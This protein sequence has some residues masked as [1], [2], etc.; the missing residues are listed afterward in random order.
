MYKM[1]G[2]SI[3]QTAAALLTDTLTDT[4]IVIPK[5]LQF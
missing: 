2:T 3:C 4:L 1:V 5:D